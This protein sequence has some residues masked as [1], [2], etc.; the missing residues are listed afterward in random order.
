[1][2]CKDCFF[3]NDPEVMNVYTKEDFTCDLMRIWVK[4][5]DPECAGFEDK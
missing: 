1:M 5:E 4:P 3:Y 2:P